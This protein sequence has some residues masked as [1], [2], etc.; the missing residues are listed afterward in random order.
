MSHPLTIKR[1][2]KSEAAT[3]A[4]GKASP[5]DQRGGLRDE[6]RVAHCGLPDEHRVGPGVTQAPVLR[7][8][9][10]LSATR[11]VRVGIDI[12]GMA[13]VLQ[14]KNSNRNRSFRPT[15]MR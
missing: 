2:V 8:F 10:P 5:L 7:N 11:V 13:P 1:A 15:A 3:D 14:L 6:G 12:V 9:Y 4:P